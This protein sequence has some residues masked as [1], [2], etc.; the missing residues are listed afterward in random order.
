MSK[1]KASRLQQYVSLYL[2]DS[3]YGLDIHVVKEVNPH[4]VITPVPLSESYCRGLVNIRGQIV[5]VIDIAVLFGRPARPVS[6]DSQLVIMKT[7]Q[8]IRR[9]HTM[10]QSYNPEI[11]GEKPVAFLA[12]R[13]GDVVQVNSADE[14]AVPAHL[15]EAHA[16]FVQ[17]VTRLDT[18]VLTVLDPEALLA[19]CVKTT[20]AGDTAP[21]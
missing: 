18:V 1:K 6:G 9:I 13:I 8:E 21:A 10:A 7:G 15:P 5:L 16:R 19:A 11:F 3:L 2:D 14:E 20:S 12:D 17:C 4:T